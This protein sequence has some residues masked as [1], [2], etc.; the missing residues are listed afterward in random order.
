MFFARIRRIHHSLAFRL[1]L[2]YAA[3]FI[4]S[5][6]LAFML[7]YVLMAGTLRQ[8]IEA[9]LAGQARRLS[10][11]YALEGV[12]MLQ[13]TAF[14]QVQSAGE[15]KTFLRLL[16]PSGVVFAAS[17]AT[18][19][20]NIGIDREAVDQLLALHEPVFTTERLEGGEP[21][22]VLYAQAGPEII[23]QIGY[24]MESESRLLQTF[25][26]IFWLTML[27]MLVLAV[28]VGGF[29]ARR[30]LAGVASITRT[31]QRISQADLD[32]RVPVLNR[33]DEIDSLAVTFNQMLDRIRNLVVSTRQM[34]DNIAHDLRSPLTRIRGLAEVTLTSGAGADEYAHM[35][36][37]TIEE[38]D[39]LLALINTMLTIARTEAGVEQFEVQRLDFSALVQRA[40]ELF[41]ASAEDKGIHFDRHIAPSIQVQ[42][43]PAMLQRMA[44]NLIDNAIR[45]TGPGG[46]LEVTLKAGG[47][48]RVLL[49]VA[50]SGQGIAPEDQALVFNR[51]YRA[52]RSR[53]ACGFGL[54]LSLARAIARAHGG[55]IALQSIP[56]AGS[57][58][59]VRLPLR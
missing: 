42:G 11:V 48:D 54:G 15:K 36:A 2:W 56:G 6:G 13:H 28:G 12:E 17:N 25:M 43:D 32:T 55:D 46:R 1:T 37:S 40:C 26:R 33:H 59:Q 50:D 29:L 47:A 30:A 4:L 9:D 5:A 18:S 38:C 27:L 51:F 31:A 52:D 7:F 20:K 35:A 21:V 14:L 34:N 22:R 44:A 58:F 53:N 24:S 41:Q 49:E 3:L 57:T 8:R 45:Y 23:L 39:R 19:W 16:Y 10:A